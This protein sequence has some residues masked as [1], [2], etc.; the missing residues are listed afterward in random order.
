MA[1]GFPISLFY[2]IG[3]QGLGMRKTVSFLSRFWSDESGASAAE[4]VIIL[5]IL[6][7]ALAF[8]A[9]LLGGAMSTAINDT[10]TCINSDGDSCI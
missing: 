10:A 5:A 4:Y 7:S 1:I 8:S 6:G 3:T 9:F 2:D